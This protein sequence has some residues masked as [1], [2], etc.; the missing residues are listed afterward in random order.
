M[1]IKLELGKE[2]LLKLDNIQIGKTT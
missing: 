1:K 2:K